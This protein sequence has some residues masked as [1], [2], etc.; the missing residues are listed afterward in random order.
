MRDGG[1]RQAG[2]GDD[3]ASFGFLERHALEAAERQH[4]GDAAGLDQLAFAVEHFH[5]LVR[6]YRTGRNAAGDDT[7]E[8]VVGF[9]DGAE[10]AERTSFDHR[11]LD[12]V[13]HQIEQRLHAVVVRAFQRRRHPALLGGAVENR[14]VELLVGGVECGEQVEHFVDDFDR[15]RV[16]AVDLV[17]DDDGLEAHAQRFRHHEL[18]LRQRTFS[19][20]DQHQC[21]VD[22]VQDTLDLT[23]EVGVARRV[24]DVDARS[25]PVDR[26][27]LGENGDAALALEVVGVHGAFDL[28]LVGA[29][30][31]RLL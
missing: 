19:G 11:R 21:A 15:A 31:A 5:G 10:Q 25:L 4:L 12:V 28:A 26:G 17:D 13:Q 22:H 2:Q 16:G 6:F 23:A 14:E 18:G 9:D 1:V 29:V 3:V 30:H 27:G 20:V 24:D 8:E 7:A